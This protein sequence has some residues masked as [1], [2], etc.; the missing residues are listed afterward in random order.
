MTQR[1]GWQ[2]LVVTAAA[3]VALTLSI[4]LRQSVYW[5]ARHAGAMAYLVGADL[6]GA[7]LAGAILAGVDL[8][9]ARLSRADQQGA[10][11]VEAALEGADLSSANLK[12]ARLLGANLQ[13]ADLSSAMLGG[14]NLAVADLTHARLEGADLRERG[15]SGRE[16][17]AYRSAGRQLHERAPVR[18]DARGRVLRSP[19]PLAERLRSPEARRPPRALSVPDAA[20]HEIDTLTMTVTD[21]IDMAREGQITDGYA[22]LVWGLH[23]AEEIAGDGI[24]WGAELVMRWQQACDNYARRYGMPLD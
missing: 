5:R 22:C 13:H 14:A 23:R 3:T 1:F 15:A 4:R 9:R 11:L 8:N 2:L 19:D 10:N 17:G 24:A 12:G 18:S 20:T 16:P 6:A 21:A 7:D